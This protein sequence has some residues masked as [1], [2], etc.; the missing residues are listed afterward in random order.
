MGPVYL[1]GPYTWESWH[2]GQAEGDTMW[3]TGGRSGETA[4][5]DA[6]LLAVRA[7]EEAAGQGQWVAC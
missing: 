4:E 6:A 5:L 1:E 7:E 2:A 3:E